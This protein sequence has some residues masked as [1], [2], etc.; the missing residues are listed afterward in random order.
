VLALLRA[1]GLGRVEN[2]CPMLKMPSPPNLAESGGL[3]EAKIPASSG[4]SGV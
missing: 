4:G 1:A 3:V 2:G